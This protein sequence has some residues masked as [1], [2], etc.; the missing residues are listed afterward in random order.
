MSEDARRAIEAV[1]RIEAAK[2][3]AGLARLVRDVGLAEELAQDALVAA[4]ETWP[5]TGVPDNPGAWLMAAA[6]NRALDQLRRYKMLEQKHV[7]LAAEM[8]LAHDIASRDRS[9]AVD[10]A[11]DDEIG[12]DLLR[13]VF[14]ACHPVLSPEARVALTLKM[15]GGLTTAEIARAYL[16]PEPTIAQRLV[17][18]KRTLSEARV[19]FEVPRGAELEERLASVLEVIYLVFNEGFAATSGDDWTRPEL[20]DEAAAAGARARGTDAGRA[21]GARARGADGDP[22]FAA[23]RPRGAGW[24]ARCCSWTRI[25]RGGIRF[26]SGG[27]WR[28]S[29][30]RS[31]WAARWGRT[32]CRRPSRRAMPARASPSETDWVRIAA[33][34]DAL[35]AGHALARGGTQPGRG[36]GDGFRAGGGPGDRRRARGRAVDEGIPPAA[37][38]TGGL[39]RESSGRNDEATQAWKLAAAVG[40]QRTRAGTADCTGISTTLSFGDPG[41]VAFDPKRT[42]VDAV[43]EH[44]RIARSFTSNFPFQLA[45]HDT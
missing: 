14:T 17:R 22:G 13:L 27:G 29:L 18:A 26:S 32:R 41:T 45:S 2:L 21:G 8:D 15:V 7:E 34:Y 20:C 38:R 16:A 24:R 5:R 31:R 35:V 23:A 9:E 6:K 30:G 10:A 11:L 28:R 39:P 36:R 44:G 42:F 40:K 33:L 1:W 43:G 3:I 4:L 37:Q 12:D 19:P 25:G